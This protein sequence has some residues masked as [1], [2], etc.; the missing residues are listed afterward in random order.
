MLGGVADE[1]VQ[2]RAA[3][4]SSP[5]PSSPKGVGGTLGYPITLEENRQA[6]GS[7]KPVFAD[8]RVSTPETTTPLEGLGEYPSITQ[9]TAA[10]NHGNSGGP[11]VDDHGRL[12]GI[13]TLT[14]LGGE[15]ADAL[16]A[17][18]T[19]FA[20]ISSFAAAVYAPFG[21][22]VLVSRPK[23]CSRAPE[24]ACWSVFW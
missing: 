8:G 7:S 10:V 4:S 3:R 1:P 15:D 19:G 23:L 13:N 21:W 18:L 5:R 6:P 14:N 2:V 11:L 9:H 24:P 16:A 17:H 12:V 22:C 20:A